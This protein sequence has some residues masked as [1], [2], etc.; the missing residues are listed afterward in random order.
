[1]NSAAPI[2]ASRQCI[3][4][5]LDSAEGR[6]IYDRYLDSRNRYKQD[7]FDEVADLPSTTP[8]L[9]VASGYG[10]VGL[11]ILTRTSLP[12]VAVCESDAAAAAYR[13]RLDNAA[14]ADS[15]MAH[16]VRAL[17]LR[18]DPDGI[19]DQGAGRFDVIYCLN[20]M[21]RWRDTIVA[22]EH[23]ATLLTIGGTLLASDLRRDPDPFITEYV[24][25]ELAADTSR[26]GKAWLTTFIESLWSSHTVAQLSDELATS[27]ITDWDVYPD[28]PMALTVR[29][30]RR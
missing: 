30:S 21:H 25:R 18:V 2:L 1:M 12:M 29:I 10:G 14:R 9:E 7:F 15:T 6:A 13:A 27:Q 22:L 5:Q 24:L 4:H 3:P 8:L 20:I 11:N 28:G 23:L 17:S 19:P 26:D 16:R